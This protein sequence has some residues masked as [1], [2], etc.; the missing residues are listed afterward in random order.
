MRSLARGYHKLNN[1]IKNGEP[2]RQSEKNSIRSAALFK[3][4]NEQYGNAFAKYRTIGVMIRMGEKINRF[5]SISRLKIELQFEETLRDTFQVNGIGAKTSDV[6]NST[7]QIQFCLFASGGK[8]SAPATR[9]LFTFPMNSTLNFPPLTGTHDAT[10][11][12]NLP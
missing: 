1:A 4:K 2:W 11:K 10:R 6:A 8:I 9:S 5:L 12:A 7:I 3:R